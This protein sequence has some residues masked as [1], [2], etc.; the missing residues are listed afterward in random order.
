MT[1]CA[2]TIGADQ[3]FL[4]L[5]GEY[6]YLLEPLEAE[7]TRRREAG[8]LG[9]GIRGQSGLD[10]DIEIHLGAGA[11][12]CGEESALIES[13][14]GKRGNPRN[15]PP[16]PVTHGYLGR[17]TVVN[18]VE[19]FVAAALIAAHGAEWFR[20]R[21]T[22]QS[23][24]TKLLSVSG[25]CARPGIYEYP[26]GV[27]VQQILDD[28]GATGTQAVQVAGAAGRTVPPAEFGRRI[29]F[30]DLATG[31]S[32]MIFDGSRDLLEMVQN[33]TDFFVHESCGFCTPCRVGTTLLAKT[34]KKVCC[35]HS[36]RADLGT[37]QQVGELMRRTSHC[38][39]GATAA[40][41][42]LDTLEK[43]PELYESHLT[44]THFEPGFDLDAALEEARLATGRD[45]AGAHL[46]GGGV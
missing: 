13:L 43:F 42:V 30:E 5:R 15:R 9:K 11:Y 40:N 37:L 12:I 24:G 46:P 3:G 34:L 25:D 7:L 18:N 31:G 22:A 44:S 33:F 17:P 21:G 4:Y 20:S 38:G 41:P 26:F 28:C 2:A 45:D 6:L 16:F 32:F 23:T 1:L 29:A 19:T 8:L 14:E 35:G 36:T 27:T 39:L 10:F